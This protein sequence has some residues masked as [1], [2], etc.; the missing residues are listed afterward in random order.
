MIKEIRQED[1]HQN[2]YIATVNTYMQIT[3]NGE[4]GMLILVIDKYFRVCLINNP[5]QYADLAPLY[6]HGHNSA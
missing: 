4:A 6:Y 5:V 1:L 3:W 2:F